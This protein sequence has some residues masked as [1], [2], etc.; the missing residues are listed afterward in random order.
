MRTRSTKARQQ[1]LAPS[2]DQSGRAPR[3]IRRSRIGPSC[4][5]V[6][7]LADQGYYESKE[8]QAEFDEILKRFAATY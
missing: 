7:T 6:A 3:D 8:L 5:A 1:V 2:S 4:A